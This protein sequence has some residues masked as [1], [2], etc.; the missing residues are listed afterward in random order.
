LNGIRKNHPSHH[1]VR[2]S[3]RFVVC[4]VGGIVFVGEAVFVFVGSSVLVLVLTELA[5]FVG[6]EIGVVV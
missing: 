3:Y 2:S 5:V 4:A 6:M 1:K